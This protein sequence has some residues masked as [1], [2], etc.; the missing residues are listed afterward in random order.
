MGDMILA[1]LLHIPGAFIRWGFNGFKRGKFDFY[2]KKDPDEN[3]V[4]ALMLII[5]F[6]ILILEVF[7]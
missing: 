6:S 5:I 7:K 2:L 4:I 1:I 3:S